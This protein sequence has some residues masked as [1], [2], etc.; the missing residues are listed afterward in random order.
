MYTYIYMY[1]YLHAPTIEDWCPV[2][3]PPYPIIIPLP[4]P[5]LDSSSYKFLQWGG[6]SWDMVRC[7]MGNGGQP[8]AAIPQHLKPVLQIG[9]MGRSC[10]SQLGDTRS[11]NHRKNMTPRAST[12]V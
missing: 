8:P 10:A 1:T 9:V 7:W 4:P 6:P 2:T 12:K 5:P 11:G 3:M